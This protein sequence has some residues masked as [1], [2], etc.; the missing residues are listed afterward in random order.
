VTI[1]T[2]LGGKSTGQLTLMPAIEKTLS[3]SR[4]PPRVHGDRER[5]WDDGA[6]VRQYKLVGLWRLSL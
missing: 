1:T 3:F 5:E 2:S 4:L 6:D